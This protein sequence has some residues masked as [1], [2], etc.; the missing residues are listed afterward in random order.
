MFQVKIVNILL[1]DYYYTITTTTTKLRRQFP[2]CTEEMQVA[3]KQ[4]DRCL[5]FGDN[6]GE[7]GR[8]SCSMSLTCN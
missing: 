2:S 4:A 8:H 6:E 3:T 7:K 5:N 1:R